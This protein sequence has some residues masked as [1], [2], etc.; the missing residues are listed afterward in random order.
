MLEKGRY[1]LLR[2]FYGTLAHPL[3]RVKPYALL[4]IGSLTALGLNRQVIVGCGCHRVKRPK[5]C[6]AVGFA[7][8]ASSAQF[9]YRSVRIS[10]TLLLLR[11]NF[12]VLL[13]LLIA[14]IKD[15]PQSQNQYIA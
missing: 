5:I 8:L 6:T 15:F 4:S 2:W 3:P 13:P 1:P 10:V 14:I 9:F 11:H 12:S 7:S